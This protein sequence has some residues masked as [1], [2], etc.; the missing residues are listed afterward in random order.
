MTKQD[1][2]NNSDKNSNKVYNYNH[3]STDENSED[4]EAQRK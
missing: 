4:K 3:S 1:I 2:E